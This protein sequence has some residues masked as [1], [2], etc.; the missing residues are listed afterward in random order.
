MHARRWQPDQHVARADVA[1]R[2][3]LAALHRAHGK[4]GEIVV[5]ARVHA[6]HLGGLPADQRAAGLAA[7]LGDA[8][9]HRPGHLHVELPGGEIIEE[10]QRLGP[11]RQQVVD[12]HGDEVD[13]DRAVPPRL[14]GDLELGAHAIVGRDQDRVL[15]AGPLQVEQRAEAAE[16]GIRAGPPRCLGERLDGLHQRVAGIDIDAALAVGDGPPVLRFA[17]RHGFSQEVA[18]SGGSTPFW[19]HCAPGVSGHSRP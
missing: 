3:H 16:I 5:V 4:A 15:E 10:E 12:A 14:D 2:Q 7:A 6:R 13:A 18:S 19:P 17:L 8:R 11:L 1:A 9:H